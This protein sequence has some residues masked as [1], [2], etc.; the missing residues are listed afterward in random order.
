MRIDTP[1]SAS[2][3]ARPRFWRCDATGSLVRPDVFDADRI[4][5]GRAIGTAAD[6]NMMIIVEGN[7][8]EAPRPAEQVPRADFDPSAGEEPM[9]VG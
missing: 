5:Q 7:D 1:R 8:L 6:P 9:R 2:Q 4:R 3:N